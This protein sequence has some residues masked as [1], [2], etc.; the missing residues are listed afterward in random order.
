MFL[1][2]GVIGCLGVVFFAALGF[3]AY[4]AITLLS[5]AADR[6]GGSSR[7]I[8]DRP[9]PVV[10]T[11]FNAA[12][13][14]G[15]VVLPGVV[16]A[17]GRAAGGRY[18]LLR[19]PRN[20]QL[21]VFDPNVGKIV[22]V[23]DLGSPK[24][25]FAGS[26]SKLFVYKPIPGV[27]ELERWNLETG[28]KEASASRPGG[29]VSPDALVT[30][31]GVDGPVY[32]VSIPAN[33][34]ANVRVLDPDTLK[35]TPP[36]HNFDGWR[37]GT[38]VHARASDDGSLLGVT[39]P[40]GAQLVRFGP[41]AAP[42]LIPLTS[43]LGIAPQLATPAHDGH[44]VYTSNGMFDAPTATSK[45][46]RGSYT[47][48][49]AHGSGLFLSL[50]LGA[51][52]TLTGSIRIHPTSTPEDYVE[53]DDVEAPAGLQ[54]SDTG[55]VPPDQ[56]VHIWPAAG[57]AAVLSTGAESHLTLTPL[58]MP[59]VLQFSNPYLAIGSDPPAWAVQGD[60]WRYRPVVWTDAKPAPTLTLLDG[61]KGMELRNGEFTWTP[62]SNA[63][64]TSEVRVR[65][66][67][68]GRSVEQRFRVTVVD[69]PDED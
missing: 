40:A 47:L 69:E 59:E 33:G 8:T 1:A 30:G 14:K 4:A 49:T 45:G 3:I 44:F 53:L 60:E 7:A 41:G 66:A 39:T 19:T 63:P 23:I 25:L 28:E 22:R 43:R 6:A 42:L 62:R 37:G 67:V 5:G 65:A 58:N 34:R 15:V 27:A 55:D 54:A 17:V 36:P 21:H 16:D 57:L 56:R 35:E 11:T 52:A 51:R 61:P 24:A 18:L 13:E 29:V 64:V 32:L 46:L 48:P 9:G 50:P 10:P 38:R 26:A 68:G 12:G 2:C 20:S 31:V